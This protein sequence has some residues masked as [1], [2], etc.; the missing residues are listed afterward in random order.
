MKKLYMLI[1]IMVGSLVV[2]SWAYLSTAKAEVESEQ[3]TETVEDEAQEPVDNSGDYGLENILGGPGGLRNS[4]LPTCKEALK[5]FKCDKCKKKKEK[6]GSTTTTTC[7]KNSGP[8]P[9]CDSKKGE[10]QS[11]GSVTCTDKN[12]NPRTY[13]CCCKSVNVKPTPGPG[14]RQKPNGNAGDYG[15]VKK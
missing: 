15:G 11:G 12:G 10:S 3:C 6:D 4:E 5:N 13:I 1:W 8:N 14:P 9:K 7:R 2:P